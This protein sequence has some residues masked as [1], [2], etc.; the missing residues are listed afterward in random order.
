MARATVAGLFVRRR[1]M[2]DQTTAWFAPAHRRILAAEPVLRRLV[3]ALIVL[4]L[5]TLAGVVAIQTIDARNQTL[6]AAADDLGALAAIAAYEAPRVSKHQ[7]ARDFGEALVAALP[8]NA[9]ERGRKLYLADE[10]GRVVAVAGAPEGQPPADLVTLLGPAQPLTT[11]GERA[12]VMK[13]TLPDGAAALATVRNLTGRPGQI[14]VVQGVDDALAA[15]RAQTRSTVTVYASTGF[16]LALLGFA[17]HWQSS[18]TRRVDDVY[19]RVQVR[20]ETALSRGHCGLFDWDVARGRIFWSRSL[21]EMLGYPPRDE[22][23]SFGEFN[24]IAHADDIDLYGLADEIVCGRAVNID[25]VFRARNADGEWK[26]LRARAEV[27]RD[28]QDDGLRLIGICVDVTEHRTLAER[29]ATADMRLRDAIETISEAFVLWDAGNRLVTCNSKFQQLYELGDESVTPGAARADIIAAGRQ[30]V[31][32]NSVRPDGRVEDG[33]RSFEAQI[34]D[35][36]WLRINERRTKDGGFVS[37]GTD[38][39][40][41]KRQEE[42]LMDSEKALMANVADL[43]KSRQ[44]LEVQAQQLAD[45]AE[46][47]A[48]QKSE[49]ELASKA[50]SD[51]LANI[52]HELRTPLNAILGF[53]EIMVS[54]LFGPL[55]SEK[56][57]EY[58]GDIRE[59]GQYLLDVISDILD[60]SKIE[61][62][63][64]MIARETVDIDK[65]VMDAMRVITPK[66]EEKSIALR[67]EAAC[68]VT[69]EVDRRALKQILLNLLSNA[70]KFTPAGGRVTIRTRSVGD[71]MNLYIEDTGIGISKD[72]IEKL[73][74]PFEQVE[75]QFSKSHK[76]SGLGLAIARSLAEL[77]GGSMRIRST[78]G[79]GTVVLIRLPARA[80]VTLGAEEKIA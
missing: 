16:V 36:R 17:F 18:R 38:I 8:R 14:A 51:F 29:T 5:I 67:A 60:M 45:L 58:A 62:G 63:R 24:A 23:V 31:I 47:Y 68:G 56:Y 35:G 50:K 2:R 77:H 9:A 41:L 75:N 39:T 49:A 32:V 43:R 74:R 34:E 40:S 76:G 15:W 13:L 64:F 10:T 19:E 3:P 61:A 57:A 25:R 27:V 7:D 72:A 73:G 21:F 53:S 71:A 30:P 69:V 37:V 79:V 80:D 65:V 54:G 70:V 20:N 59:S 11:F 12:G 22:L 1:E 28:R 6:E 78:V 4:F 48:E 44:T 26:W 42:R 33:A 55:G 66:A 46:K 52:S